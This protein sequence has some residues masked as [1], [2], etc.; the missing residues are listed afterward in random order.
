A[1]SVRE[2]VCLLV[3]VVTKANGVRETSDVLLIANKKM[4]AEASARTVVTRYERL[5]LLR[6]VRR[7]LARVK[8]HGQHFKLF[9]HIKGLSAKAAKQSRQNLVAQH[10]ALVEDERKNDRLRVIEIFAQLNCPSRLVLE[11][12]IKR[13]L[14]IQLLL[15]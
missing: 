1:R 10:R 11:F 12:Q 6:R 13:N 3:V 15:N 4:P 14:L 7:R 9:P 2:L 8:A 5:L